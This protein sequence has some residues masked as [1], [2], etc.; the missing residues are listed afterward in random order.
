MQ[1]LQM[2]TEEMERLD[3]NIA[4]LKQLQEKGNPERTG[5]G[6]IILICC[7]FLLV[8]LLLSR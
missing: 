6:T 7:F 3:E 2:A 8:V 1:H 4:H 5:L